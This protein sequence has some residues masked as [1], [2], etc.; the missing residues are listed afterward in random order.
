[1]KLT[2]NQLNEFI[3]DQVRRSL[4]A[5]TNLGRLSEALDEDLTEL[6]DAL[7][8]DDDNM[9]EQAPAGQM[10]IAPAG[11]PPAAPPPAPPAPMMGAPGMAPTAPAMPGMVPA[12]P[13]AA[14][15]YA[16]PPLPPLP[17]APA[18]AMPAPMAAPAMPPVGTQPLA[19][20]APAMPTAGTQPLAESVVRR[21]VRQKVT[22]Y[23]QR[24]GPVYNS[25]RWKRLANIKK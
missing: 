20:A 1:M 11:A 2:I 3:R 12:P 24:S 17:P 19:V 5:N 22:E 13:A 15:P 14:D 8:E 16:L 25:E 23:V 9:D 18:P 6:F 7:K 10:P 21:I 4:R